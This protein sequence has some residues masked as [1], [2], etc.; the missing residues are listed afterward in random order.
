M[1]GREKP[2]KQHR[3]NTRA[4]WQRTLEKRP[5]GLPRGFQAK[6]YEQGIVIYENNMNKSIRAGQ[7]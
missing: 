5:I 7:L 4:S 3:K 2:K 1:N 6:K